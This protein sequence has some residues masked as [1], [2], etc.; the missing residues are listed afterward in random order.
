M[1]VVSDDKFPPFKDH[2][3]RRHIL[4]IFNSYSSTLISCAQVHYFEDEARCESYKDEM[5]SVSFHWYV[6]ILGSCEFAI[7]RQHVW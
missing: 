1:D 2:R 3:W 4:H 7:V 6:C 5:M